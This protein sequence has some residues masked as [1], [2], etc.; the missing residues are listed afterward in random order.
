LLGK[1]PLA[2]ATLDLVADEENAF[3]L[4]VG[5]K[6][7]VFKGAEK[8]VKEWME[9]ISRTMIDAKVTRSAEIDLEGYLI[10][11]GAQ[12]KNWKQRWFILKTDML[13]Y[14]DDMT[15]RKGAPF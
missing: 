4:T 10:K 11:R 2:A 13:S 3:Q 14:Y 9:L 8:E 1:L 15:V 7:I 6:A 5:K 12:V